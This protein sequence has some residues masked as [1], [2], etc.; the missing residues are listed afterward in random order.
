MHENV[1]YP[2]VS[3]YLI[4][5]LLTNIN[6]GYAN[7]QILVAYFYKHSYNEINAMEQI[8]RAA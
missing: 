7:L 5:T 6:R 1:K 2:P 3:W 4:Y 8:M